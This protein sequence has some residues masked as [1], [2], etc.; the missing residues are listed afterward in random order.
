MELGKFVL[1]SFFMKIKAC[2]I[3][4]VTSYLKVRARTDSSEKKLDNF[5]KKFV[6]ISLIYLIGRGLSL[7]RLISDTCI[8][9]M[10]CFKSQFQSVFTRTKL[11]VAASFYRPFSTKVYFVYDN[12]CTNHLFFS[13]I[14]IDWYIFVLWA[15]LSKLQ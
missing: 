5:K 2:D 15:V 13:F 4:F 3:V 8:L 14:S 10:K 9:N 11:F 1:G 12:S 7:I 6:N